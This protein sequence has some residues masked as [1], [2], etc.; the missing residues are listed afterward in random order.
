MKQS[1]A[2]FLDLISKGE[3]EMIEFKIRLL[4][5]HDIAK[6]LTAF[7]NTTGG[8]LF[9]GIGDKGE[10]IGL[11]DEEALV[12]LTRLNNICSSILPYPFEVDKISIKGRKIVYVEIEKAPLAVEY[13]STGNGEFYIRKGPKNIKV[14]TETKLFSVGANEIKPKGEIIGF[15]AMSFRDEEEPSLIDFFRSMLRSAKRTK[16]PIKLK[17]IDLAEGDFEISQQ[18]MIEIKNANF[19]LADFT[20]NPHN[21]YFEVGFARGV[22]KP[23][24]QTAK[25][26][27]PLQFDVRNWKTLFYRNATELE[28]LLIPRLKEIYKSMTNQFD[29]NNS[30]Y[31]KTLSNNE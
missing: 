4:N 30:K 24:I 19:V 28:E 15:V 16:L 1:E 3:N 14:K 2:F 29:M 26:G 12:T 18:I 11:S 22:E 20:L 7:A 25:K 23:I 21:V 9:I 31:N 8:Y 17:R 13:L 6:V 10:I 5:Q 27:T